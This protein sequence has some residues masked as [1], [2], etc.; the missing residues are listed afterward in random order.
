MKTITKADIDGN[1]NIV[2]QNADS[3]TITI[4][5][6]NP[7][8]MRQFLIDFQNQLSELPIK[9]IELMESKRTNEVEITTGAN[10]YLG[11][12]ILFETQYNV[13]TGIIS[14]IAFGITIT[15]LTKENRFFNSPFFK[16]SVPFEGDLDT[17][18]MTQTINAPI[19]FPKK[20]EYG[21]VVSQA[22]Q[23]SAANQK[24]YEQAI[25]KDPNATIQVIVSTTIG[26]IYK[27]NEYSIAQL[28]ENFKYVRA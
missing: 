2:I 14:G 7:E 27:S 3:S 17:F 15:N 24:M 8:E 28:L 18:V 6:N 11:L 4:N 19:P 5:T 13:P 16:L 21:E 23:I 25:A 26:E 20:L 22:Y 10:V 1:G 12:N 9:I